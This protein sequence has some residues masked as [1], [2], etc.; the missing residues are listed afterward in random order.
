[1]LI[2]SAF[3]K[4][5]VN[6]WNDYKHITAIVRGTFGQVSKVWS[7]SKHKGFAM[8]EVLVIVGLLYLFVLKCHLL[9]ILVRDTDWQY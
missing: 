8:K 1:M 7:Y 6:P 3:R 4:D 2:C 9:I 5:E